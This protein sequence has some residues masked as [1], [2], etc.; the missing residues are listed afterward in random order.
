MFLITR[1]KDSKRRQALRQAV[2]SLETRVLLAYTLDPSFSGDGMFTGA[3]GGGI[4]VQ[5]DN[6]IIAPINGHKGIT[7]I[8]PDGSVDTS[9]GNA[10]TVA[11]PFSAGSLKLSGGKLVVAGYDSNTEHSVL[12]RYNLNGTLDT[13]FG[14]GDGMADV[15]FSGDL[16]IAP[17]AIS[18]S[19]LK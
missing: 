1:A 4:V 14:G 18:K 10:G 3:G 12:A 16:E 7:R 17:G 2:E 15:P 5:A 8:N 13:S 11:T 19:P 9:F 6:K